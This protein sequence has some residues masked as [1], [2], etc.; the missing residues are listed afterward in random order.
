MS[1]ISIAQ[2]IRR[3]AVTA[4]YEARSG[5]PGGSLSIADIL[6]VLYFDEMNIDPTRPNWADRDRFVLSKGHACPALYAALAIKGYFPEQEALQ[7]RKLNSRMEGHPDVR[8]PGIDAPSGS[9]GMGLSQTLGMAMAAKHLQKTFRSYVIVGDGDMQ[10][11]NTWEAIMAAPH[12]ALDNMVAIYD[13]NKLQ[14]DESVKVQM[15]LGNVADKVAAFGWHVIEINGH[16]V[17]AIRSALSEAKTI[18]NKPT[19]IVADTVKGK[20]ISFMEGVLRWHGSVTMTDAE[21][22]DSL[23]ALGE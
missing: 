4:V 7:L 16:D 11:G 10:E 20:G 8:I 5:H 3:L 12:H 21:L 15:D 19:F 23:A 2:D 17:E 6:A 13:S 9:L 14:G 1:L 18:K 22:A